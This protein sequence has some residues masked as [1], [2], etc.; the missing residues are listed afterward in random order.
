MNV[1]RAYPLFSDIQKVVSFL[2]GVGSKYFTFPRNFILESFKMVKVF[3]YSNS[4][5]KFQSYFE[6]LILY[7][8]V[9]IYILSLSL[10][11]Y[12]I[13]YIYQ[14]QAIARAQSNVEHRLKG[15]ACIKISF[16]SPLYS[17]TLNKLPS[18]LELQILYNRN[19]STYFTA[20]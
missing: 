1:V 18:F 15:Q 7:I 3:K 8:Y 11:I 10:Y 13:Y 6:L 9:C 2:L 4:L 19:L 20:L 14:Q 5:L 16:L 12:I 17:V